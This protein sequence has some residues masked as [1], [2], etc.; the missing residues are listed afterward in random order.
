V[1]V[2]FIHPENYTDASLQG[3]YGLSA[4]EATLKELGHFL[5]S[6]GPRYLKSGQVLTLEV[7]N[8]DLAGRIEWWGRNFYD[9][10]ILRDIYPPRFT[11]NYRLAE[12]G[13]ILVK[14][15]ETVVDPNYLATQGSTF[16]QAPPRVSKRR[17]WRIGS[18][19]DLVINAPQQAFDDA[20]APV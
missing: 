10:R 20:V 1:N 3:G 15:Q 11:L 4:E 16:P 2:S 12:V 5:E 14:R 19:G 9:T 8:I 17:C 18:E 6:L 13:R 7:L